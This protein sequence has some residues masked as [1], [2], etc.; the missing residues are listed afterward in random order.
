MCSLDKYVL[1][2]SFG[3][4]LLTLFSITGLIWITQILRQIDLITS[5]GQTIFVFLTITSLIIPALVLILAPI[6][7][8]LAVGHT[9]LKLNNDSELVVMSAAGISP[10]RLFRPFLWVAL[11]V[12]VMVAFIAAYLAPMLQREMN[13]RLSKVRADVVANILRP[14]NFTTIERGLTFHIREKLSD[15]QFAG[16]LI[17][18]LRDPEERATII[19]EY[20]QVVHNERGR[21]LVM[22][23][24]SVQRRRIRERDPTMVQFDRYAFNL[25]PFGVGSQV[26]FGL[27]ER[28]FWELA[29]PDPADP[30]LKRAP[31]NFSVEFHDR[32][33]APLYPLAFVAIAFAVLGAPRTTRQGMMMSLVAVILGVAGVRLLGFACMA[34]GLHYPRVL[35]AMYPVIA[36]VIGLSVFAIVARPGLRFEADVDFAGLRDRALKTIAMLAPRR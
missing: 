19:S 23:D 31:A 8:V 10:A 18:D 20:G 25:S 12:S 21:F 17:D 1:R 7:M 34:M 28:Y 2:T 35:L 30:L 24:G 16:V 13:E 3:A 5:Q 36:V 15:N 6:A 11:V 4:F 9:L 33:L 27:R 32:I 26:T 22:S 29:N 14:G